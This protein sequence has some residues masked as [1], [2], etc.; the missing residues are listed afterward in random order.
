MKAQAK[1]NGTAYNRYSRYLDTGKAPTQKLLEEVWTS[2]RSGFV[3]R[4]KRKGYQIFDGAENHHWNFP[5]HMHPHQVFDPRNLVIAPTRE[6][7]EALHRITTGNLKNIWAGPVDPLH[8]VPFDGTLPL[9]GG[10]LEYLSSK[11]VQ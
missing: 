11:I 5:K 10:Y 2:V 4:A 1:R 8:R 7:H 6:S 9:P 3:E